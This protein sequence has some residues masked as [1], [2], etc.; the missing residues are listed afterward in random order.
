MRVEI[1]GKSGSNRGPRGGWAWP[2][3]ESAGA[4]WSGRLELMRGG[5]APV[6]ARG[7]ALY[8]ALSRWPSSNMEGELATTRSIRLL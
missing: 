6:F 1:A 5:Q 7:L 4:G 8:S 3:V 2:R